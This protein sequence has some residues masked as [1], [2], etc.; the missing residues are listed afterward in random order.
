[1]KICKVENC[2]KISKAH[3]YCS[4]HN[5]RYIRYGNPLGGRCFNN[6]AHPE[7]CTVPNCNRK[8]AA[9]GF[10]YMHYQRLRSNGDPLKTKINT[11]GNG[12]ITKG[13]YKIKKVNKVIITE[14]RDIMEKHI[15]RKL[16]PFPYEVIHHIDGNTLNNHI[17]NLKIMSA[18][19][20]QK[21]HMRLKHKK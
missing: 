7:K 11:I 12:H 20:H 19:E 5:H 15:G 16:L 13:G 8:Y 9:R 1:M 18:S 4:A 17:S 14:H 3:G 21:L 2:N 6:I 10:C